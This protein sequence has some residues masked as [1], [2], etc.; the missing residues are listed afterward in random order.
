M[1][2]S[3]FGSRYDPITG[4][5]TGHS[6][7]DLGASKSTPIC[8]V[9]A[10]TV[11]IVSYGSTGYGYHLNIDHG[12]GL[13]TLYGHCSKILVKEGQTVKAGDIIARIGSTGRSTGNHLHLEVQVNGTAKNPRNYLP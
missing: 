1:V 4:A 13:V 12:D 8:A 7:L 10:G 11:K 9:K 2:T 5:M 6:G 3:E